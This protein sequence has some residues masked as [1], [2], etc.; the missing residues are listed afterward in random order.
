MKIRPSS[1]LSTK[2][3][4]S[5][6]FFTDDGIHYMATISSNGTMVHSV[7]DIDEFS[8]TMLKGTDE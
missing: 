7:V 8:Y 1:I 6:F 4:S 3:L 2:I 5:A